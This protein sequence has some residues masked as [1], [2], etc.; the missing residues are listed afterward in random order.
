MRIA[1][2]PQK[3]V[4]SRGAFK[5]AVGPFAVEFCIDPSAVFGLVPIKVVSQGTSY[6]AVTTTIWFRVGFTMTTE[7]EA[8]SLAERFK[9][10]WGQYLYCPRTTKDSGHDSHLINPLI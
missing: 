10:D 8:V 6:R 7:G 1:D 4:P 2:M 5:K 9:V 3:I